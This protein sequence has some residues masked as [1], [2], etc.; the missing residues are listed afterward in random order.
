[1]NWN[2]FKTF[3]EQQGPIIGSLLF[4]IL[5]LSYTVYSLIIKVIEGKDKE[6]DR[7][8]ADNRAY[9]KEYL[10]EVKKLNVETF[11]KITPPDDGLKSKQISKAQRGENNNE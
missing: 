3:I 8:A 5:L 9:R 6:I 1:L 10:L 11:N 7:L 2:F 4:I